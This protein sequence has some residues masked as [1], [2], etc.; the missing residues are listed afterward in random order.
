MSDAKGT[1]RI[2]LPGGAVAYLEESHALPL[3]S[4]VVALRSGSAHDPPGKDGL[5]RLTMRMLRRG[6]DGLAA[7][8]IEDAIDRLGAE[9][10]VDTGASS[11]AIHAQVIGR[12]LVPFVDLLTRMLSQPTFPDDELERLKRETL[13]EIVETRDHDRSLVQIAFRRAMF[14]G[15]PYARSGAGTLATVEAI[16]RADVMRCYEELLVQGNV[17]IGFAGDVTHAG[18]AELGARL[19]AKLTPKA[20]RTDTVTPPAPPEGRRLV[21]VDKPERTQ[22]QILIGALGT[23]PHDD[24]HV[25]LSVANAIFGGTFTSRLMKEVRSKRGWSYGAYARLSIDRQRQAFSM[26]TFPAATDAAACIELELGLLHAFVE[27]GVT[28][29]ET[30]FIKKYL[31]RSHA[32]DIDTA[33]KRLHQAL[34]VEL[35]DLPKTYYSHYVDH[36]KA[37]TPEEASAAVKRRIDPSRLVVTVV[38]TASELLEPVQK[39]LPGLTRHDVIPFDTM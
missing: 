16:T 36:V 28:P 7:F 35:L 9:M 24:D 22:T 17:V 25:A 12:N 1:Q 27:Q 3:V 10:S 11:V 19:V 38:G 29:R 20:G 8:Q 4:I 33:P 31:A 5:T 23:W 2:D 18:A 26:W 39:V 14:E 15:H 32:F 30:A 6:C 21:F 13:A 34:D 37:V